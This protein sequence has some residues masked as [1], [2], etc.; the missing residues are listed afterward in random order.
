MTG[1]STHVGKTATYYSTPNHLYKPL[2]HGNTI[3]IDIVVFRATTPSQLV[4][5]IGRL[6]ILRKSC[7]PAMRLYFLT[8]IYSLIHIICKMLNLIP[9]NI[10]HLQSSGTNVYHLL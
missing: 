4:P 1:V 8:H 5:T 10:N 7:Y 2:P 9:E 3:S 6:Y